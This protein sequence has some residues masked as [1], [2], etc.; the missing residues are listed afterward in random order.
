MAESIDVMVSY[1]V[2]ET[3]DPMK[4]CGDGTAPAIVN[5][6]EAYGYTVFLDV[7]NLEVRQPAWVGELLVASCLGGGLCSILCPL[8]TA[9]VFPLISCM[10][11]RVAMTMTGSS[12]VASGHAEHSCQSALPH[13]ATLSTQKKNSCLP[14]EKK[15]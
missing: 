1:R 14:S 2:P 10:H 13:M 12:S 3:G 5:M 4:S 7:E 6:L 11:G 8:A 15:R 9:A